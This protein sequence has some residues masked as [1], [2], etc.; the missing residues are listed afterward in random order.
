MNWRLSRAVLGHV[1]F[2][3]AV[4]VPPC[5]AR[6]CCVGPCRAVPRHAA[7]GH[8]GPSCA[9][10]RAEINHKKNL[11][12]AH[13]VGR[14]MAVLGLCGRH[15]SRGSGRVPSQLSPA[16]AGSSG[17]AGLP[18]SIATAPPRLAAAAAIV[19]GSLGCSWTLPPRSLPLNAAPQ[20][21]S[22]APAQLMPAA[23][24]AKFGSDGAS[25]AMEGGS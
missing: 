11:L 21:C 14:H 20:S 4:L 10:G 24:A 9:Y 16:P 2:E 6:L 13:G 8:S 18:R 1:A 23:A 17:P 15:A 22:S 3:R 19:S 7:L 25:K 5:C 12:H